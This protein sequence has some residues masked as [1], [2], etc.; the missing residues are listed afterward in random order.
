M[1]FKVK[2]VTAVEE[3]SVQEVEKQ[4]LDKHEEDLSQENQEVEVPETIDT[5]A[6]LK[7]EDVLSYIGKR[8]NKEINS[9]DELMSERE[10]QE[11]LPED[12]SKLDMHLFCCRI[13]VVSMSCGC[14]ESVLRQ[15]R[16]CRAINI[17]SWVPEESY[18][19]RT[20]VLRL[21]HDC[22]T[23]IPRVNHDLIT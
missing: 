4:L 23:R 6:E 20:T 10:T 21:S 9:F 2:E 17:L 14:R 3:K 1:E 19:C 22:R 15:S 5:P 11:E 18:D 16:D 12:V 8:Y 7:E 13:F